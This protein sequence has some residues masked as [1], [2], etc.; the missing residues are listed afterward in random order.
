VTQTQKCKFPSPND[1]NNYLAF[2]T[3]LN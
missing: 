2:P 1:I 3:E